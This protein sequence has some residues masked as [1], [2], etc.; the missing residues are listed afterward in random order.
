MTVKVEPRD[1]DSQSYAVTL[2]EK[3]EILIA[4][5]QLCQNLLGLPWEPLGFT[6]SAS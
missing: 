5:L 2:V 4:K 3:E 1:Y 6:F